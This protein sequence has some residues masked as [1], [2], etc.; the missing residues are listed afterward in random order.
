MGFKRRLGGVSAASVFSDNLSEP[1]YRH[2]DDPDYQKSRAVHSE[3]GDPDV[4]GPL[5]QT[6]KVSKAWW[7]SLSRFRE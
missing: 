5:L 3:R 1:K 7:T 6:G 2:K 4:S